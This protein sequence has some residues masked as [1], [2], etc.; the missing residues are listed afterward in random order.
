MPSLFIATPTAD[1][2]AMTGYVEALAGLLVRLGEIGVKARYRALDGDNLIL[3]RNLLVR[4]FLASDA[5]H[6]LFIDS[7]MAFP[8][9]LAERLL[10]AGKPLVGAVYPKRRLDLAAL[11]RNLD[12]RA[13]DDALALSLDWNFQALD[14]SVR[15]EGGLARVRA[16]PG[17]FLLIERRVFARLESRADVIRMAGAPDAPLTFF[18][19]VREGNTLVDLDYAF[20]RRYADSGGE[21]WACLDADIRHIGDERDAPPF[22][23]LLDAIGPRAIAP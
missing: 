9:D 7:D 14:D 20:C 11:R 10:A 8:P 17:G 5:T 22:A 18:R 13:F 1:G 3:Q 19:E 23:A 6:L 16:L 4:E 21:V 15:R 2:V 12:G